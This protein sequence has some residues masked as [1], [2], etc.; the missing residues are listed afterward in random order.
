M[1]STLD[2]WVFLPIAYPAITDEPKRCQQL[3]LSF[4]GKYVADEGVAEE[5]NWLE[6]EAVRFARRRLRP[7]SSSDLAGHLRISVQHARRIL[8][9]LTEQELVNAASGKQR[10]RTYILRPHS[11]F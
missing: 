9:R 3:I 10:Y 4:I 7:F 1:I 8:H 5:P 2:D 11:D 6:A